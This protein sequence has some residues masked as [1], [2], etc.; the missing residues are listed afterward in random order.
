MKC[1]KSF[2]EQYKFL[3]KE[4]K[5]RDDDS[6]LSQEHL[7]GIFPINNIPFIQN[8]KQLENYGIPA[9]FVQFKPQMSSKIGGSNKDIK[10]NNT[11]EV[12]KDDEFDKLFSL[13]SQN[14]KKNKTFK[15]KK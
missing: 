7:V 1:H 8:K 12:I 5:W 10:Q 9:G 13:V 4:N 6:I 3:Q 15:N 11:Q 14:N 2:I